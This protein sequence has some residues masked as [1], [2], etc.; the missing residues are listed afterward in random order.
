M[1]AK[2]DADSPFSIESFP[3]KQAHHLMKL[4]NRIMHTIRIAMMALPVLFALNL[5]EARAASEPDEIVAADLLTVKE[6]ESEAES[7][8]R[9]IRLTTQGGAVGYGDYLDFGLPAENEEV[10]LARLVNRYAAQGYRQDIF[11]TDPSMR[12]VGSGH[13]VIGQTARDVLHAKTREWPGRAMYHREG[14][15]PMWQ[16]PGK[17]GLVIALQTALLDLAGETG[18]GQV[19][20]CVESSSGTTQASA[21]PYFGRREEAVGNSDRRAVLFFETGGC[22]S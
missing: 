15:G 17:S 11:L 1:A 16:G 3:L 10:M 18:P 2:Y 8:L 20:L 7:R 13:T 14:F 22:R 6:P 19:R 21:A 9:D 12:A 5:H 4:L